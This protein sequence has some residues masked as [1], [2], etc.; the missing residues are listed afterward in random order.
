MTSEASPGGPLTSSPV[1]SEGATAGANHRTARL[2]AI[3]AGLLGALLAV[4]TPFLPVTQ[5]TAQLNWPQ[6]G[7]LQSVDAP[8]IGYVATDLEVTHPLPRRGRPRRTGEHRADGPAV[9][10]A[11]AG[12]QGR[13]PRPADRARRRRPAGHRA[14]HPGRH[15]PPEPGAQPGLPAA[16]VHRARRAG[17]PANSSGS[18]RG[19]TPRVP[20][21]QATRCGA[22][23]VAM[24]S[25]PQIVGVFT[26]LHRARAAGADV[27]GHHRLPV[28][29][30]P[31]RCSSS[32]AMIVGIAMTVLALGALHV[33]DTADGMKHRRFLPP[34][35]WSMTAARRAGRRGAGL[36]ALRRRQHLRRRLHPDDGAGVRARRLHGQLLPLVR[37][38]RGAVRLV[39]R[40]ARAV[41]ARQHRQRLGAAAHPGDGAWRAGG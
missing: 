24:T 30:A 23:A 18:S 27:L 4:A 19:R 41:G 31:R 16:D 34:R 11:Q 12:A 5:T 39:L 10:R 32:L 2:I 21:S 33:L 9:D 14:Q 17:S 25:G 1:S 22:S 3:V 6:N 35:W 28:Q 38:A 26:D 29:H 7:V 40:P 20:P 37:H 13:R 15:R 36:V 8:L